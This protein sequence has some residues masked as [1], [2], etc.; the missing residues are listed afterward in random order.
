M[1]SIKEVGCKTQSIRVASRTISI[2]DDLRE[3]FD[4]LDDD[5][6]SNVYKLLDGGQHLGNSTILADKY[7]ELLEDPSAFEEQYSAAVD[8]WSKL[9][10]AG[11][12]DEETEQGADGE[13]GDVSDGDSSD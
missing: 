4:Q 3:P 12:D 9:K 1:P 13:P 5:Q 11:E 6:Q 7:F 10:D 2:P 8:K